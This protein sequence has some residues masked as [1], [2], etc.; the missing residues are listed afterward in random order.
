MRRSNRTRERGITSPITVDID[1]C[2]LLLLLV[3]P[4]AV[5]PAQNRTETPPTSDRSPVSLSLASYSCWF[6]SPPSSSG[7]LVRG[8]GFLSNFPWGPRST[9]ISIINVAIWMLTPPLSSVRGEAL[10]APTRLQ[11]KVPLFHVPAGPSPCGRA[12][13]KALNNFPGA[14]S[15]DIARAGPGL[16]QGGNVMNPPYSKG[17]GYLLPCTLRLSMVDFRVKD[18]DALPFLLTDC[19]ID[20]LPGCLGD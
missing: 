11:A 20:R 15:T 5:A 12:G 7:S 17:P 14:R 2:R 1:R 8:W 16:T 4:S 18:D 10:A 6:S 19:S 3:I 9:D 13:K